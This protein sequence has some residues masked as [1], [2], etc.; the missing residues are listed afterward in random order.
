MRIKNGSVSNDVM[1]HFQGLQITFQRMSEQNRSRVKHRQQNS[2]DFGQRHGFCRRKHRLGNARESGVVIDYAVLRLHELI[3]ND[4][5]IE[6]NDGDT[7]L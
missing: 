5:L 7:G 3:I 6:I 4:F 1:D 2:L